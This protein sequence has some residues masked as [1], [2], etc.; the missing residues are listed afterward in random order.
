MSVWADRELHLGQGGETFV[1]TEQEKDLHLKFKINFKNWTIIVVYMIR[2]G[3]K[4]LDNAKIYYEQYLIIKI[5]YI[6]I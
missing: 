6:L 3:V 2:F 5:I 1:I 4:W